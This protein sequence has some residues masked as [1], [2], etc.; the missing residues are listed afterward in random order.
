MGLDMYMRKGK[1]IPKK[2]DL[3]LKEILERDNW[4]ETKKEVPK[5]L[6]DFVIEKK[7]EWLKKPV[8]VLTEEVGY[9]RKANAIHNW[10]VENVQ[11]G[12]DD[13]GEYIVEKE[14][15]EDLLE[16]CKNVLKNSKLVKGKVY[17]GYKVEKNENDDEYKKVLIY[18]D[19]EVIEDSSYIEEHLPSVGGF[20]FGGTE[21]DEYYIYKVNET[22]KILEDILKTTDFEKEYITYTSS[23]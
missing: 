22:V 7:Y 4:F 19:G 9:W 20:F 14:D 13:C 23:W 1:R 10:F 16:T 5:E 18:E 12:I 11:E 21:Y 2:S 6:K 8:Y 17:N 15:I 3:E